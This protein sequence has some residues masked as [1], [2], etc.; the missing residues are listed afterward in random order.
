[1]DLSFLGRGAYRRL[2]L[3]AIPAAVLYVTDLLPP[4]GVLYLAALVLAV[5]TLNNSQG[6]V[7]HGLH[8][9]L[10]VL[11][12]QL[13]AD[14]AHPL[15]RASDVQ[16]DGLLLD[17]SAQTATWWSVQAVMAAYFV[18][19]VA[20]VARTAFLWVDEASRLS[21]VMV[22]QTELVLQDTPR[23]MKHK[24]EQRFRIARWLSGHRV[25]G[26]LLFGAGLWIEL[27]APVALLNRLTLV[28]GG[29]VLIGLHRAIG[30]VLLIPFRLYQLVLLI[31][32]VNVPYLVVESLR[33]VGVPE[34]VLP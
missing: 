34:S 28:V 19:G 12:A 1:M 20:K 6:A 33:W 18:S 21:L 27:L 31:Y 13:L 23:R 2:R 30:E 10:I 5:V 24:S 25:L 4:V 9:S 29:L 7:N 8:L 3:G 26:G 16:I 14:I 32:F 11:V 15:I 17:T 22:V